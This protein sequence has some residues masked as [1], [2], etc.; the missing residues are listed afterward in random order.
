MKKVLFIIAM[1]VSMTQMNAQTEGGKYLDPA[2]KFKNRPFVFSNRGETEAIMKLNEAYNKIDFKTCMSFCADKVTF[3]D[4][5]GN[6]EVLTGKDWEGFFAG[7]KSLD[8]KI[9]GIVPIRIKDTDPSSGVIVVATETRVGKDGTVWKKELT[10]MFMFDLNMKI[11]SITQY[12]QA[13]K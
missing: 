8:W 13:I 9:I 2:S 7:F 6:K 10:E 3:T 5:E 11:N 4:F 12:A 1:A